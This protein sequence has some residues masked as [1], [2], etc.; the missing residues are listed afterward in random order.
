MKS[1]D[2]GNPPLSFSKLF[3]IIIDDVNEK[4]T[5]VSVSTYNIP[6]MDDPAKG[7]M[8]DSGTFLP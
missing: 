5:G 4:P 6:L 7:G 3:T 2:N 1:T 8:I